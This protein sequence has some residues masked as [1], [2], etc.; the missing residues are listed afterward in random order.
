MARTLQLS[1]LPT[2]LTVKEIREHFAEFGQVEDVR[3]S[4]SKKIGAR[5]IIIFVDALS[6]Q[7]A[8]ENSKNLAR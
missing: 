7:N 1:R 5:A 8:V 4:F 3:Y 2:T 6:R